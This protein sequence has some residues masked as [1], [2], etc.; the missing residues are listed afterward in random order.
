M[1]NNEL[2]TRDTVPE[3]ARS[4]AEKAGTPEGREM[5][6][7]ADKDAILPLCRALHDDPALKYNFL[8]DITAVD[9]YKQEPRFEIVYRMYSI[10]DGRRLWIKTAVP[11]GEEVETVTSVWKNADWLEREVYD[12]F[13]ARFTNHPDL[14]RILMPANWIG[15]PLRKDHPLGNEEVQ[16]T[17]NKDDIVPQTAFLN[18]HF[19]GM[20]F[21]EYVERGD[22]IN[23]FYGAANM[24]KYEQEGR[25]VLNMGP[26]HP[27]THGVLRVILAL[28]GETIIDADQDIGYIHTGIEKTAESLIYQQALTLTD[29]MDYV[30]PLMN[31][32]AYVLP[33]EKLLGVEIPPRGQFLRV[34]LNELS[35]IGS[36]LI[37]L[38][39]HALELGAVSIFL[40]GFRDREILLDIF[41]LLSGQRMM[42]SWINVGGLRDDIPEGFTDLVRY[43]LD[44]FPS[45]LDDYHALLTKNPIWLERTKGIGYLSREDAL[46]YGVSGP[47]LRAT[48]LA[49]DV[50]KVWP[51]SAYE[52]FEF[53]IPTGENSDV[54]DRYLVR[55]E[56]I[57]QSLRIVEQALSKL[58]EGNYR[59]EDYKIVLPP[60]QRLD[61]S[62]EALIHHFLV[63]T[64]GFFVPAGDAYVST[65]SPR[66]EMGFYIVSDG[67]TK[68]Y[69]MRM[70]SPSFSTLQSL[71]LMSKGHLVADVVAI[72]GSVDMIM[73]EVDR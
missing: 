35:R 20:D 10:P 44:V 28:E 62:M 36:H 16:F 39:T 63:P 23:T 48:G 29:R 49:W 1:N 4:V 30:A 60:R 5:F 47:I 53:D 27:S 52:E 38:G 65:E 37:W 17:I 14:R 51:Y 64:H 70:R 72:L 11:T 33:I 3:A 57:R 56:E 22:E 66:G 18:E 7:R 68:P 8:S 42:T 41:E 54:Y 58:P 59:I 40:Y 73:G 2:I 50:R 15:H 9:L 13:G 6:L 25:I 55:M 67:G 45:R 69:R 43:F 26:Q 46:N 31:N 21:A 71:P 32:F 34:M 61:V 19:E 12:M 24:R